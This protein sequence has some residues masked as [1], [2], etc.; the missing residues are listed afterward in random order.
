MSVLYLEDIGRYRPYIHLETRN[1]SFI[2][3]SKVLEK[4]GIHNHYFFLSLFQPELKNVDPHDPN[5]SPELQAKILYESK[6]N[7]WYYIREVV[8]I[9]ASGG[10]NIFFEL[11]RGNLACIWSYFNDIDTGLVSIRQVGKT[12]VTQSIMSWVMYVAA[13]NVR[14]G[15]FSKDSTATQDAVRRLKE[16]R[17]CLP[18]YFWIKSPKDVDRKESL[19]YSMKNNFY[20][21]FTASND[22]QGAY[23]LG[24]KLSICG[25]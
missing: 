23:K 3:M 16:L 21:T 5:L 12:T 18:P 11:N 4:M 2:R 20:I 8:R 14:I 19:S 22:E 24:R 17:D 13:D 25:F 10:E 6:I 15:F 7:I 9:P 1:T